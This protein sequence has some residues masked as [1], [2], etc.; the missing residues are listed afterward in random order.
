[1]R[2]GFKLLAEKNWNLPTRGRSSIDS[3]QETLSMEFR[4][5]SKGWSRN[6]EYELRNL[7]K[8]LMEEY[9]SLYV[10]VENEDLSTQEHARLKQNYLEMNN[11]WL[12]EEIKPKQRSR[13]RD[14][15]E[16]DSNTAYFHVVANQ[17]RRKTLVHSCSVLPL[18]KGSTTVYV[19]LPESLIATQYKI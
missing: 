7:K 2:T 12:K 17:R 15:K 6:I 19:L 14:I 3:W 11:L 5:W 16:G 10:K 9:D 4:Q 13:D 18:E 8:D 1:M